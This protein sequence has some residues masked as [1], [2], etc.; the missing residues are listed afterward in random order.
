MRRV[1]ISYAH[2][3]IKFA[4]RLYRALAKTPG[5]EPWLDKANLLP[6]LEWEP[7]IRKAIRE[8]E[9]FVALLSKRAVTK[10]GFIQK[11][12]KT[13]LSIWEE[14]PE[15]Q[16]YLVPVRL[17]ECALPSGRM[18]EIHYV[19][20]FPNWERG[21]RQIL[22]SFD[23]SDVK[24]TSN[25]D[26]TV[27]GYEYRCGIIDFD[28]GLTNLEQICRRLNSIQ[29]FFHFSVPTVSLRKIKPRMFDGVPN[30]FINSLPSSLYDQKSEYL[31]VDLVACLTKYLL[32]FDDEEGLWW[33]HLSG[34]SD[35]DSSV[36][37]VSTKQLYEYTKLAGCT[38]EKGIVYHI[39]T[40]LIIFFADGLGFHKEIKG[41][42]LD[43]TVEHSLMV[44][45]LTR[46]R[47]CKDCLDKIKSP[48][49]MAATKAIL[50]DEMRV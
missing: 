9:F 35:V 8:S 25:E 23:A 29:N 17:E 28:N 13:A 14:F 46:M 10:R 20:L 16:V 3:D 15:G 47:L 1:F 12:F 40:Q 34:P 43:Y 4:R 44:E 41:C 6:G 49:L 39:L 27:S 2:E 11:E 21:L 24:I 37:F 50:A 32:A 33:D 42:V 22:K 18:S 48:Q 7:A 31:N 5:V 26:Y 38:F 19:D 30:L 45:G 36:L